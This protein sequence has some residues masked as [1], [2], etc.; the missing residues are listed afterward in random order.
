MVVVACRVTELDMRFNGETAM[1]LPSCIPPFAESIREKYLRLL[2][3]ALSKVNRFL[4]MGV[5]RPAHNIE[6][7]LIFQSIM[8]WQ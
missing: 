7:P 2:R 1:A 5:A 4:S 8:A 6:Q 3:G